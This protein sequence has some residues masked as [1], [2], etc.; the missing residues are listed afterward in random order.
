MSTDVDEFLAHFGVKGMKWGVKNPY[1]TTGGKKDTS[2]LKK[3]LDLPGHRRNPTASEK[4]QDRI[5]VL[6][7]GVLG[8]AG[9]LGAIGLRAK[10]HD[11]LSGRAAARAEKKAGKKQADQDILD[12]RSRVEQRTKE[13]RKRVWNLEEKADTKYKGKAAA[14]ALF[15]KDYTASLN[16]PDKE[17]AK[18]QTRSEKL[19]KAVLL[20][21]VGV[22]V[23]GVTTAAVLR[24]PTR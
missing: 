20:G 2:H 11:I 18:K 23:A 7:T 14:E 8:T 22:T 4:R 5:D 15:R 24:P 12:A 21:L 16:H 6:D 17:L 10:Q 9:K 3:A 19:T 13:M 1:F